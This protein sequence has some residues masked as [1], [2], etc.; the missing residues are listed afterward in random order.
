MNSDSGILF[1]E[2]ILGFVRGMMRLIDKEP[3][4][5]ITNETFRNEFVA[6]H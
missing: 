1:V 3:S 5:D 4:R 2:I 6:N